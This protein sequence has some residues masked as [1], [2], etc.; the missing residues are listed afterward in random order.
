MTDL[1]RAVLDANRAFYD[2]FTRR[3]GT[4]MA[5]VWAREHAVA[6]T[7]PGWEVLHGRQ[8]VVSSFRAILA[9]PDAP[10]V[11]ASDEHAFVM[12]DAAFV[13]CTEHVSG[14]ELSATNVFVRESGA[15]K[16]VHHHASATARMRPP[17]PV[18][19]LN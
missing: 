1:E 15:W 7:H 10:D 13:T 12:G 19:A 18:S 6:C 16:M 11:R 5:A 4:A 9:A 8:A 3:D 17:P 14:A 2:A